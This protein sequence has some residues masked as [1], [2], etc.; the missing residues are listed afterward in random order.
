MVGISDT[1]DGSHRSGLDYVPF[2]GYMAK[3]HAGEKVL[4]AAEASSYRNGNRGGS[5]V[6]IDIT[7][8]LTLDGEQIGMAAAQYVWSEDRRNGV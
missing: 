1:P 6:P 3:L 7:I 2:D 8:P 4:T 5:A